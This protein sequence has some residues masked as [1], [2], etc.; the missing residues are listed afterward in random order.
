MNNIESQVK[1]IVAT[2]LGLQA[3]D[4]KNEAKL[5]NDLGADSL[6][7]VETLM[8][9]EDQFELRI[10]DEDARNMSTVQ[11]LIDHVTK[12]KQTA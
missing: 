2:Q 1:Q 4:I 11:H 6:D 10:E 5:V 3:A 8:A 12:A 9:I 7:E